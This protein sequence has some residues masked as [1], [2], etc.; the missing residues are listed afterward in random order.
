MV[1][2]AVV[3]FPVGP[4]HCD[5]DGGRETGDDRPRTLRA[6]TQWKAAGD[7]FF[8]SRCKAEGGGKKWAADVAGDERGEAGRRS[9]PCQ[10]R[11]RM[12]RP[13]QEIGGYGNGGAARTSALE[14]GNGVAS[15]GRW[16]TALTLAAMAMPWPWAR[17]MD[18]RLCS[19]IIAA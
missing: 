7:G 9:D 14:N 8:A 17:G 5:L 16:T 12:E 4:H 18:M 13:F 2:I 19:R 10:S 3:L 11:S 6:G 1:A 15:A